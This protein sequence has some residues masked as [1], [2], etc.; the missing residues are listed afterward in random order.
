MRCLLA[1]LVLTA[2]GAPSA[3]EAG[4]PPNVL[5]VTLDTTRA[6]RLGCYGDATA[7]TPALDA[8]AAEGSLFE[9]AFTPCPL[10]LPAHT[11]LLTGLEPP[12]HGVRINGK[13]SLAD[14]VP[15]LATILAAHGYQT[16]AF[17]AAFVLNHR[18]GLGRG[19]GRYDDDLTAAET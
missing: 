10:T 19:F 1:L 16:A 5:L 6:D 3:G 12:Q 15:T 9:Q 18:F 17:V 7:L 13:T 4:M 14:D 11:T 8:L 2:L